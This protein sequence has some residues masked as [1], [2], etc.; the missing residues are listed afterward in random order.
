M[1]YHMAMVALLRPPVQV[2]RLTARAMSEEQRGRISV[3]AADGELDV[4]R[5]VYVASEQSQ[6]RPRTARTAHIDLHHARRS[7]RRANNA[8]RAFL[9]SERE[10]PAS[11]RCRHGWLHLGGATA[12]RVA[13]LR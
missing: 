12:A 5:I 8:K 10:N 9:C 2:G 11:G 13:K 1:P 6:L 4:H 3:L 7:S